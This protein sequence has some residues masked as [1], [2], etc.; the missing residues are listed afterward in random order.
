MATTTSPLQPSASSTSVVP[1]HAVAL[2][3]GT[4][5]LWRW[6]AVRGAGFPAK[7]ILRLATPA[8]AT[9][10]D[11]LLDA[12]AAHA[13]LQRKVVD[14]LYAERQEIP[15]KAAQKPY[16]KAQETVLKGKMPTVIPGRASK[17][18]VEAWG[19]SLKAMEA[20]R[21]AFT[22]T[23]DAE[24][25]ALSQRISEIAADPLFQE[26]VIW[27][28]RRAFHTGIRSLLANT[29]TERSSQLRQHEQLVASYWQRYCVKNDTVGFF[30]PVGWAQMRNDAPA[31][32]ATPGDSLLAVRDVYFENWAIDTLTETLSKQPL[33]RQWGKPRQLPFV[34]LEGTSL[35]LPHQAPIALGM[36]ET[37]L[38]QACNGIRT[39]KQIAA[40]LR[41]NYANLFQ[42]EEHVYRLLGQM[43]DSGWIHWR[44][45]VPFASS[46]EK[47]LWKLLQGIQDENLRKPAQAA[48]LKM[49]SNRRAIAKAAGNPEALDKAFEV[50]ENDFVRLTNTTATRSAGK[51]YAARTLVYEDGRRNLDLVVGQPLLEELGPTL[52]I[53][54]QSARWFTERTVAIYRHIFDEIYQELVRQTG[55]T[56]IEAL[57]CWDKIRPF[58][59][60]EP[61]QMASL[62]REFQSKWGAILNIDPEAKRYQFT[63][64]ALRDRV[65][66]AFAAPSPG[67]RE[68]HYHCPDI[69]IAAESVE[70]IARGDYQFVLGE[71]HMGS[72][73]LGA[74]LFVTQHPDSAQLYHA[75]DVDSP[76]PSLSP[77][78]PR[79]FEGITARTLSTLVPTH[80]YRLAFSYDAFGPPQEKIVTIGD[81]VAENIG[82]QLI[83]RTRDARLQFDFAKVFS[84]LVSMNVVDSFRIL[85]RRPHS[86]RVTI[87][88]VVVARESWWLPVG[89]MTFIQ[90]K[91]EEGR[92]LAVRRW[93]DSH[94][95]PR[96]VFVKTPVETKPYFLDFDSPVLVSLFVKSMRRTLTEMGADTRVAL[97]EMVPNLNQVWLP[98]GDGQQYTCEFRVVAVDR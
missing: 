69:M 50:L 34:H 85:P 64:E 29:D 17:A 31:I 76:T 42:N 10:A 92:F 13:Q 97:S 12:E 90:E 6:F 28:N 22:A 60:H 5:T 48:V 35:Y 83:V 82:G 41:V 55:S 18:L 94:N 79:D 88:N 33:L 39:A 40:D 53:L 84:E 23:F 81:L 98:D 36:N 73:T 56:T 70:A 2:P 8:A 74:T 24:V 89:E 45:E 59:T 38:F 78:V 75:T 16:F 37:V 71:L 66:D 9:A 15:E 72:H 57:L 54:L 43:H 3:G 14:T 27:Q 91:E 80:D 32:T 20:H 30:G 26:A 46:P 11:T 58:V 44:L 49:E 77:I 95:L 65:L 87:D 1:D 61:P 63:V 86:P 7:A 51:T 93:A 68:A 62:S 25:H 4:W 52:T 19:E 47:A 96:Q 21:T 67:L